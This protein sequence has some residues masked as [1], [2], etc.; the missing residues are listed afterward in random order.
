MQMKNLFPTTQ[1]S[2]MQLKNLLPTTCHILQ[3]KNLLTTTPLMQSKKQLTCSP[4]TDPYP[5]L[6]IKQK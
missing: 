1:S 6:Y 5:H 2:L 4:K 3:L